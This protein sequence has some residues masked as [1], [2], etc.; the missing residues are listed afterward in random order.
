MSR[1]RGAKE[2][3]PWPN[4]TLTVCSHCLGSRPRADILAKHSVETLPRFGS[5]LFTIIGVLGIASAVIADDHVA[6]V[7]N[8]DE[9][10]T[11]R[12]FGSGQARIETYV[13]MQGNFI[14]SQTLDRSLKTL[15]FRQIIGS[16][17][18]ELAQAQYLPTTD[19]KAADLL[20]VVHWGTTT[21]RVTAD[22]MRGITST[23]ITA[24]SEQGP[25]ELVE[26]RPED[27][28]AS[29][30]FVTDSEG[31]R[32][33]AFEQAERVADG[34]DSGLKFANSARLLGYTS[35]LRRLQKMAGPST[36]EMTLLSD[37]NSER[38]FIIV[39]AYDLKERRVAGRQ[40]RPVW[41]LH[42]NIRSPGQNFSTALAR[43]G[44]VAVDH[45][46]RNTTGVTTARPA[47]RTGTVIIGP[48]KVI[49]IVE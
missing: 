27:D 30:F 16:L 12:K 17:A 34:L 11:Q 5:W 20:L 24:P 15:T 35:E 23:G 31:Y 42:L 6:V 2:D 13:F 28:A 44:N 32:Q 36:T 10:Y 26:G 9:A 8:A 46:G 41:T 43:M 22:E 49:G 7:A 47:V 45:F 33:F 38:Y 29:A 4:P 25:Q 39:E 19:L 40:R 48:L 14:E 3:I 21:P 18:Q 1:P 37:L